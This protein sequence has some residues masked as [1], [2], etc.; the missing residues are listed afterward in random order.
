MFKFLCLISKARK[1]QFIFLCL[2]KENKNDNS[3]INP[4]FPSLVGFDWKK[5]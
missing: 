5:K 3:K 4:N 2:D 1:Q